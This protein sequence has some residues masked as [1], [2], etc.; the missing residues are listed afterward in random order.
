M[1]ATLRAA[2]DVRI[3]LAK[4]RDQHDPSTATLGSVFLARAFSFGCCDGWTGLAE[5]LLTARAA[6]EA[7]DAGALAAATA[8]QDQGRG[9][10]LAVS[11][12][13][14]APHDLRDSYQVTAITNL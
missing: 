9:A 13:K 14:L 10:P 11:L 12:P 1:P 6:L 7:V 2:A 3:A 5:R 4:D 8:G